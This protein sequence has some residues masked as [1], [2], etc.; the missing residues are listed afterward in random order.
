MEFHV[1]T[2]EGLNYPASFAETFPVQRLLAGLLNDSNFKIHPREVVDWELED[3]GTGKRIDLKKS[4]DQ[5]GVKNGDRLRF[6]RVNSAKDGDDGEKRP[7]HPHPGGLTRCQNGHFFDASKYESC[8]FDT[9]PRNDPATRSIRVGS[10]H[11]EARREG[12]DTV[13]VRSG[14]EPSGDDQPT[15][16]IGQ[17]PTGGIDA[18]VGWLVCVNG[19]NKGR[20]YRIRS[21]N[22][23]VGRSEKMDIFISGDDLISR[24]T[25]TRIVFDPQQSSFHVT[26]GQGRSLVYL[27]GKAVLTEKQLKAYDEILLGATTL[28]F[29]PFCGESFKWS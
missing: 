25:H 28:R 11:T 10:P 12:G 1:L 16:R 5:N 17:G 26:P 14:T 23:T 29:V 3:E 22:N 15:R 4:L 2:P 27:N 24:E 18:V 8:P 6:V 7:E 19:V 13:A 21:E 9:A 20:D